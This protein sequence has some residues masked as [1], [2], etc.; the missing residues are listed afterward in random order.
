M[1]GQTESYSPFFQ[2]K[3]RCNSVRCADILLLQVLSVFLL[4]DRFTEVHD[5]I[6]R[7]LLPPSLLF[8]VK[9]RIMIGKP[10]FR[11]VDSSNG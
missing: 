5:K 1:A 7:V 2:M 11:T 10:L 9:L 8:A 6:K 4:V 3:I